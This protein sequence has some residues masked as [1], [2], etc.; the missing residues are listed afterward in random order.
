LK[1]RGLRRFLRKKNAVIGVTIVIMVSFIALFAPLLSPYSY[2]QGDL[3]D[4]FLGIGECSSH[5]LGTDNCG[6]DMLSRLLYGA[7]ISILIGIVAQ[8]GNT[9]IGSM[10]GVVAAFFG[11]VY[12]DII[13]FLT[14]V[15]LSIPVLI[16]SLTLMALLGPG[17]QNLLIALALTNWCYTCRM[18]RSQ[19]LSAKE[20]SYVESAKAIGCHPL[21]IIVKYILP[22]ILT[23][24]LVIGTLGI[25]DAILIAA[26][27]GFLGLGAQPPLPEWGTMLSAGRMYMYQAP[28]I[29]ILPGIAILVTVL[30]FNLFG[31]GVRDLMD[32]Y[33]KTLTKEG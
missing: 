31:D 2:K 16:F 24:I 1:H 10:L 11:G 15:T 26:S 4:A 33:T 14:N 17:L 5:L 23:P 9:I 8:L 7:R 6:R 13:M 21:R 20:M 25:G 12:D 22:N 28:W 29:S 32:P 27:L 30:G 18:A 19:T 3:N